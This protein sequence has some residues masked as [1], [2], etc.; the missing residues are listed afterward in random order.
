MSCNFNFDC[1][2]PGS[3]SC[4]SLEENSIPCSSASTQQSDLRR[5]YDIST[6]SLK[7]FKVRGQNE[8][9]ASFAGP[10]SPQIQQDCSSSVTGSYNGDASFTSISSN[11]E[12]EPV[13]NDSKVSV[14]TLRLL[15]GKKIKKESFSF[16]S[17]TSNHSK[18]TTLSMKSGVMEEDFI[19]SQSRYVLTP[20]NTNVNCELDFQTP[21]SK[22][23][24]QSSFG[25]K[26]QDTSQTV[27][28]LMLD[29][30]A[31]PIYH[32]TN[33]V[34]T[35]SSTLL[36]APDGTCEFKDP[37]YTTDSQAK[38]KSFPQ[39]NFSPVPNT[40]MDFISKPQPENTS[41]K[42]TQ[43][44]NDHLLALELSRWYDELDRKNVK[45]ERFQGSPNEYCFRKKRKC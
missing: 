4:S 39:R 21:V 36:Y 6:D 32:R 25:D 41:D 40:I 11:F 45:V 38:D 9:D 15:K 17:Q 23:H 7:D 44:E 33:K 22:E 5:D 1:Y 26:I 20:K 37:G 14:A 16:N 13:N 35:E 18:N 19:S 31:T 27:D 42:H 30:S 12:N 28:E 2:S 3:Q 34:V 8:I 10:S 29:N 24:N 43:E